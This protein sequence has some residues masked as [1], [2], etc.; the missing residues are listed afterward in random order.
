MKHY[1]LYRPAKP[2]RVKPIGDSK[3][4]EDNECPDAGWKPLTRKQK[5]DLSMLARKAA[6]KRGLPKWEFDTYRHDVAK[7]VCGL[8]ISEA[9][10]SHF[11]DLLAAFQYAAGDDVAAFRTHLRAV[12]NKRRVAMFKLT[13]ALNSRGLDIAYA[14]QIC[15]TQF[16]V[17]LEEATAKQL[18][19]LFYTVTKRRKA[20]P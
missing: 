18:W 19:C 8:R 7:H 17:T 20:K 2:P 5:R 13:E 16:K 11:N 6:E 14:G 15:R 9:R 12:D 3:H 4:A 10:Q 1:T